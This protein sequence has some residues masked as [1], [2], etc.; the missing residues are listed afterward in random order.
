M[1]QQSSG[2]GIPNDTGAAAPGGGGRLSG[3]VIAALG[4]GGLLLIFMLQ[5]RNDV[6][7]KFLFWSFSMPLWLFTLMAAVLGSIVWIGLGVL[8]RPRRRRARR[9]GPGGWPLRSQ[10]GG[11]LGALDGRVPV[12]R[13]AHRTEDDLRDDAHDQQTR[14][15]LHHGD[16]AGQLGH[17]A[18]VAVADRRERR[19]GEVQTV[20]AADGLAEGM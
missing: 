4:G 1:V 12:P 14:E 16:D 18:D 10:P 13:R 20:G 2:A 5:N 3:G 17:R 7:L 8:R 19:D 6:P 11:L 9:G 15:H